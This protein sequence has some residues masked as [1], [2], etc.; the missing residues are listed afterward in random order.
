MADTENGA[1][2]PHSAREKVNAAAHA[3]REKASDAATA[4][5]EKARQTTDAAREKALAAAASAREKATKA[6][7]TARKSGQKAVAR[8][9]AGIEHNPLFAIAGGIAI[10]ALIAGLLPRTAQEDRIAGNVGRKVRETAKK[11][12]KNVRA[13]AKEQLD[14]LGLNAD[15]AK[16]QLRGLADKLGKAASNIGSGAKPR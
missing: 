15:A 7:D 16:E 1:E 8:T 12:A 10:G 9:S 14:E 3:A 4:A 6:A 11:T 13:N 5:R 2:T